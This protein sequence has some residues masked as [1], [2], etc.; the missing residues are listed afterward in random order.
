MSPSSSF[1][2]VVEP[3]IGTRRRSRDCGHRVGAYEVTF[4]SIHKAAEIASVN[5]CV[6]T[7]KKK[8]IYTDTS[9]YTTY[10]RH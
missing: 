10:A 1:S 3:P 7:Y 6:R 2:F 5:T 4:G 9:R 8:E